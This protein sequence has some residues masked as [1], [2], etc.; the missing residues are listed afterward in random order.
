MAYPRESAPDIRRVTGFD[1]V[2]PLAKL[3]DFYL[4]NRERIVKASLALMNY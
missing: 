4:P 1:T 2:V 3:E